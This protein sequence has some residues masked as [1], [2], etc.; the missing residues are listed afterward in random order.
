MRRLMGGKPGVPHHRGTPV[1]APAVSGSDA[2]QAVS[3]SSA[4]YA[5]V[6]AASAAANNGDQKAQATTQWD[7]SKEGASSSS[8]FMDWS[9][10]VV[11][12][13]DSDAQELNNTP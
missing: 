8:D 10:Y 13:S 4:A 2:G 1:T 3:G 7:F 5:V 12:G 11:M 6:G 9:K